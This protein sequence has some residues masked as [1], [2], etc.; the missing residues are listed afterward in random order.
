MY[1]YIYTYIFIY[2]YI[3]VAPENSRAGINEVDT[4]SSRGK[5]SAPF[6]PKPHCCRGFELETL[7]P[8]PCCRASAARDPTPALV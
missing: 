8:E 1:I 6:F 3:H 5:S 4:P 2:M 7:N